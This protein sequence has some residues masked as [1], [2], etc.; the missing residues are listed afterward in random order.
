M[1][2]IGWGVGIVVI[3]ITIYYDYSRCKK[4]PVSIIPPLLLLAYDM[5]IT[6]LTARP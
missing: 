1:G 4:F 5:F 2:G 3:Y 6:C